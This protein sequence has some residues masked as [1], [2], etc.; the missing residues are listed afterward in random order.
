MKINR[1][2]LRSDFS[3]RAVALGAAM[4]LGVL[5]ASCVSQRASPPQRIAT[6]PVPP[7]RAAPPPPPT[8]R[9]PEDWRDRPLTA[10]NWTYRTVASGSIAGFSDV[11][12]G[13]LVTMACAGGQITVSIARRAGTAPLVPTGPLPVAL[14]TTVRSHPFMAT[15]MADSSLAL[16]F[17][18]SDPTL[19]DLAF[20]RGRFAIE[21]SGQPMLILPAWEEV[22]RVIEDCR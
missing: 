18:G 14:V 22:G 11:T 1:S 10:G 4:G 3:T 15:A 16:S 17:R 8:R 7:M 21:A 2:T 19:D 6:A 5:L 9:E 12:G 13:R 20:S